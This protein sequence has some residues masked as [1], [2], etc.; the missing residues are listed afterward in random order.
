[1]SGTAIQTQKTNPAIQHHPYPETGGIL[2][3]TGTF[4]ARK[5]ATKQKIK[6]AGLIVSNRLSNKNT[7][8]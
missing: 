5:N 3:S 7:A 8:R 4:D 6:T 1:L 2:Q